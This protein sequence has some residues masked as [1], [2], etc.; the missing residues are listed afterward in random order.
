MGRINFSH[1][2][3]DDRKGITG[4]V[5]IGGK[6]LT[7]PWTTHCLPL[8]SHAFGELKWG[9]VGGVV[10]GPAFYSVEFDTPKTADTFLAMKGWTKGIAWIN[11]FNL[12]RYWEA[13]GPQHTLYLPAPRLNNATKNT[14]TV[15]EL[16]NA[17]SDAS[18]AF[19][20]EPELR[21]IAGKSG[22]DPT[23]GAKAGAHVAMVAEGPKLAH[24][25]QWVKNI[26][27]RSE[28]FQLVSPQATRRCL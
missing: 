14:L 6:A 10:S 20:G 23:V 8:E 13:E 17:S 12:G 1:G 19:L 22:C 26:I 7:G 25:Q 9:A 2:M 18:F 28:T 15:L 4:D 11:G 21:A 27:P 24:Q 3:D 5:M 16:H